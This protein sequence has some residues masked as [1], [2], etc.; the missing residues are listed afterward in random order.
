VSAYDEVLS[1]APD[2]IQVQLNKALTLQ[3]WGESMRS[4][5]PDEVTRARWEAAQ[6]HA[7]HV[8]AQAPQLEEAEQRLALIREQLD[9]LEAEPSQEG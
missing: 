2:Q 1:R 5:V 9:S 4:F 7:E 3:Q 8:L 6:A